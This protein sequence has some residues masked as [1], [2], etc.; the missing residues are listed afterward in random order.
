MQLNKPGAKCPLCKFN[1]SRKF[2]WCTEAAARNSAVM[3]KYRI[4]VLEGMPLS[5]TRP[6]GP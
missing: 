2:F 5:P 1:R 3:W 4:T 6:F